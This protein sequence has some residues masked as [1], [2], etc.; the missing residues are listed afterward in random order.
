MNHRFLSFVLASGAF[1]FLWLF[2]GTRF[3][4]IPQAPVRSARP[5]TPSNEAVASQDPAPAE[6]VEAGD[7]KAGT[8]EENGKE[9]PPTVAR[10]RVVLQNDLLQVELDNLGGRIDGVLLKSF[11]HSVA[12]ATL[13]RLV[14]PQT[15]NPGIV[16]WGDQ[17]TS[18]QT[19]HVERQGANA[20][21][22][23]LHRGQGRLVK[24]FELGSG[25]QV[26]CEVVQE[27]SPAQTL[28]FLVGQGLQAIGPKDYTSVSFLRGG[29]IPPKMTSVV[30]SADGSEG[31]RDA[32]KIESTTLQPLL[33]EPRQLD[34]LG[35]A[36]I[37]FAAVFLP[38]GPYV[39]LL[40]AQESVLQ[41]REGKTQ[42]VPI[43]ALSSPDSVRGQFF[44]GPKDEALVLSVDPRLG[45]LVS[46]GW[47]GLLS[48]FFY[49]L[50]SMIHR[51][52]GN[53]GWSIILLTLI[54]RLALLPMTLPSLRSSL[55]MKAIQPKIEELKKKHKGDDLESKQK[56]TQ[57][58]FAL[59]KKEGINPFSSCIIMLPQIPVFI[60]YF[61]LLR[62]V[63]SLRHAPFALW[64]NDLSVADPTYVLPIIMGVTMYF[65]QM[66]TPMP[67]MDP[68][69]QKMMKLMPVFITLVCMGMPSGLILY[70]IT[71]NVFQT[72]QSLIIKGRT[73]PA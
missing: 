24:R 16:L 51:I 57:E 13:V 69:Q 65:G 12:D 66:A 3:G 36:D 19:F 60:A 58:T 34:W 72:A 1:F 15:F 32:A 18:L 29:S 55:K 27:G 47:A 11:S 37:Y 35:L 49:S 2:L 42:R 41:G 8:T 9:E 62:S 61:S 10:E 45:N 21:V 25:Y 63:F 33:D 20:V 59:Y 5:S 52:L 31:S 68:A 64:I 40:T 67:S 50:L 39:N 4:L 48:K 56:L 73:A 53:W 7:G 17:D 46:Y 14:V 6:Q 26:Q 43:V 22:F 38:E 44:F 54:I 70:M 30:W 28:T 71:S 23:T